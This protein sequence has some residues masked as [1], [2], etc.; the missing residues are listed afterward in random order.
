MGTG[1]SN[2]LRRELNE[3]QIQNQFTIQGLIHSVV[4]LDQ[5]PLFKIQPEALK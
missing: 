2:V 5:V 4:F 3:E 1:Q